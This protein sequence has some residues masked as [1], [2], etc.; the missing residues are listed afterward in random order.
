MSNELKVSIAVFKIEHYSKFSEF[1]AHIERFVSQAKEA[2]SRAILLPEFLPMGLLWTDADAA[3]V[4]NTQVAAFYRKVL[5]PHF[6]EFKRVMSDLAVK[7]DLFIVGGSYWHEE[8]GK[9]LNSGFVF[10]PDGSSQRQDKLHLTRGE[11]AIQTATGESLEAFEI[12]GV[13]CGLFV[14]YDVQYPELT[15]CLAAQG[16]EVLFVPT[17][18]EI[19]GV[20]RDWHSG[21]ARALEN[22]MFVCVST[23]VGSLGIPND[24]PVYGKG[25]AFVACP[26]DNRFKIDDGTYAVSEFADGEEGLLHSALDLDTLRL[27]REKGEVRQLKD[28]RPEL[29][30]KLFSQLKK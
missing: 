29:Y 18:T 9:G 19:R 8:Q 20:W 21:H 4:D 3:S 11:R 13:K 26:I 10:R 14:C 23:L 6:D 16:V 2:G 24:Y 15:Q 12:D 25:Q 28:R 30:E 1:A 17:L 5:T 7:Y 22:Q 27:S